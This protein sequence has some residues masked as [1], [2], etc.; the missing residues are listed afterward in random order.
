LWLWVRLKSAI[1]LQNELDKWRTSTASCQ[2]EW[3]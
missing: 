3:E 1:F 2:L